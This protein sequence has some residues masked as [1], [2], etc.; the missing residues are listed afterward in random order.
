MKKIKALLSVFLI[1]ALFIPSMTAFAAGPDDRQEIEENIGIIEEYLADNG[2]AVVDEL[3][4]QIIDLQDRMTGATDAEKENLEALINTT[5]TL[6][7]DYESYKTGPMTRGSYHVVYSPAVASVIAYFNSM[8]YKL[9][10]ELLTHARD[11]ESLD[12]TYFPSYGNR[13]TFSSVYTGII[14]SSST[15]GNGSFPKSGSTE[16]IDLYYGVHNFSYSKNTTNRLITI[17]DRY[18]FVRGDY[19]GIAG[20]ATDTMYLA[21]QAGTIVPFY[22]KILRY[23]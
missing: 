6:I 3:N 18:D 4:Q 7:E 21:Q 12:A 14:N 17:T 13:V 16:Q 1:A 20:V 15:S 22:T 19:T 8:G 5:R 11:N 23:Y 10:A 2:T 9:S